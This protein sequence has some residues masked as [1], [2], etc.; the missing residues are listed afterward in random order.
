MDIEKLRQQLKDKRAEIEAKKQTG[1]GLAKIP[2]G[3]SR[4][5]ILPG[6]REDEGEKYSHNFGQHWFKNAD[7]KVEA[8]VVCD[9]DTFGQPCPYDQ[10]IRDAWRAR[11]DQL[12][13][14][15]LTKE[16]INADATIKALN[17]MT[18]RRVSLVNACPVKTDKD[19]KV[20]EVGDPVLL[21]FGVTLDETFVNIFMTAL[22]DGVNILSPEDGHDVII[23]K[24]GTGFGTEYAMTMALRST[25]VDPGL[26]AK[27]M[28]IDA[29]IKAERDKGLQKATAALN[30]AMAAALKIAGPSASRSLVGGAPATALAA[31]AAPPAPA[32]TATAAAA[33]VLAETP[34]PPKA[35]PVAATADAGYGET[36]DDDELNRLLTSIGAK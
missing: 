5:R 12:Q 31:P 14:L 17:E 28:N 3:S 9:W 24:S 19:G 8:V 4:W 11:R 1:V 7:G 36:I 2:A 20:I 32:V 26:V 15:G 23:S 35:P 22:N 21:P 16:Q 18:S 13:A 27:R 34:E 25:R 6:W 30:T 33:T 10:P 29:W